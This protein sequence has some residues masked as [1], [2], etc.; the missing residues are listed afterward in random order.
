[1]KAATV[2]PSGDSLLLGNGKQ[3]TLLDADETGLPSEAYA[4][5]EARGRWTGERLFSA[6]PKLYQA[7]VRLIARG[8]TYRE[9]A[10][11]CS[12]SVNTVCGV[13]YRERLPIES[14]RERIGR[15]GLDVAQ[16]TLETI[17][18]LLEDPDSRKKI[19]AKDLAVIHGITLSNAQ[20][21]LGGAT[22]RIETKDGAEPGHDDYLRFL[23]TVIPVTATGSGEET[24]ATKEAASLPL[25]S[26]A[27]DRS[28]AG[29]SEG[30]TADVINR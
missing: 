30:A 28:D 7:I 14:I 19:S 2:I 17:R 21:V 13:V 5:H 22:V 18:D 16:L 6:N 26:S 3:L 1:M 24:P 29:T 9:I 11:V 10:E 27:T 20:L 25:P 4:D 12:V 8:L 15:L 23:K